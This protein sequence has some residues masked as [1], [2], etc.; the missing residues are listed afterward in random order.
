MHRLVASWCARGASDRSM[1]RI[2][3]EIPCVS[4]KRE[5]FT[6][7]ATY[8]SPRHTPSQAWVSSMLT[9]ARRPRRL[10]ARVFLTLDRGGRRRS[11]APNLLHERQKITDPPMIGDLSLLHAHDINRLKL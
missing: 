1:P 9:P 5:L 6:R 8:S 7:V 11:P 4:S 3:G 10:A 2:R